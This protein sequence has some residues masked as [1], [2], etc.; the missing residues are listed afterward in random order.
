MGLSS[1]TKIVNRGSLV[2]GNANEVSNRAYP[3]P[4]YSCRIV[5]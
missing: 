3:M 5:A 2:L 1:I 4:Q